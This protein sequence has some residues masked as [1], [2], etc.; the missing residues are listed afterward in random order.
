MALEA[1][2]KQDL[3]SSI[4]LSLQHI[5]EAKQQASQNANL[6]A[7]DVQQLVAEKDE[8][9]RLYAALKSDN[10]RLTQDLDEAQIKLDTANKNAATNDDSEKK[11]VSET[12]QMQQ[13]LHSMRAEMEEY[14]HTLQHERSEHGEES[15]N[16]GKTI[17]EL[18]RRLE[19][20]EQEA[21]SV[22]RLK[23]E[24]EELRMKASKA[25]ALESKLDVYR[26]RLERMNEMEQDLRSAQQ[27]NKEYM[28]RIVMLE[29]TERKAHSLQQSSDKYKETISE[30]EASKLEETKR[31]DSLLFESKQAKEAVEDLERENQRLHAERRELNTRVRDLEE[32]GNAVSS[33]SPSLGDALAGV[34]APAEDPEKVARLEAENAMLRARSDG[35]SEF[36]KMLDQVSADKAKLAGDNRS[37]HMQM[38]EL[39]AALEKAKKGGG[40]NGTDDLAIEQLAVSERSLKQARAKMAELETELRTTQEELLVMKKEHSMMGLD[41]KELLAEAERKA[42]ESVEAKKAELQSQIDTLTADLATAQKEVDEKSQKLNDIVP[43]FEKVKTKSE[44]SMEQLNQELRKSMGLQ[45]KIHEIESQYKEKMRDE[46]RKFEKA[47]SE[48]ERRLKDQGGGGSAEDQLHLKLKIMELEKENISAGAKADREQMEAVGTIKEELRARE[49]EVSALQRQLKQAAD[50][51]NSQKDKIVAQKDAMGRR[52]EME[53]TVV[54]ESLRNQLSEKVTE[55]EQER[56]EKEKLR[57]Q[58]DTEQQMMSSAWHSL[59]AEHQRLTTRMKTTGTT[60]AISFLQRQRQLSLSTPRK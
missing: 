24:V 7:E 42:A 43:E 26:D 28:Q 27:Q 46:E 31:G 18:R 14:K 57:S 41:Q 39:K 30:L 4:Q 16:F 44:E 11:P 50:V 56:K 37:M 13:L 12:P 33:S 3:M 17:N 9:T 55:F 15:R 53:L 5:E 59:V 34:A 22:M 19:D 38:L 20:A 29:E 40:R 36:Q 60:S 23:D 25:D 35:D 21:T 6:S 1:G 54:V 51:A 32:G 45:T 49:G 10:L 47:T 2:I 58:Y 52:A 48:M 8:V